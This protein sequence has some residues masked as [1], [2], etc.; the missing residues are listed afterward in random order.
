MVWQFLIY[1]GSHAAV[2][3]TIRTNVLGGVD[4]WDS[5]GR[6]VV[7]QGCLLEAQSSY[8]SLR[9]AE[10]AA[11]QGVGSGL[12]GFAGLQFHASAP[13]VVNL[14]VAFSFPVVISYYGFKSPCLHADRVRID[15]GGFSIMER[16]RQL[17]GRGWPY[18]PR[19]IVKVLMDDFDA[20]G[21]PKDNPEPAGRP[22]DT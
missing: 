5:Q 2:P 20:V 12:A 9:S 19:S 7:L 10:S 16:L 1:N 3:K 14:V 8:T 15:S 18:R 6:L 11:T 13:L 22:Q 21:Q 4:S 17:A